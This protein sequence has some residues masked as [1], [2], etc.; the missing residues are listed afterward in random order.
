MTPEV[1]QQFV[2]IGNFTEN[3]RDA[4]FLAAMGLCGEAGEVSELIKKHLLHKKPL[5]RAELRRELGDVMWYLFHAMNSFDFTYQE[6]AEQNVVKLCDRYPKQ[7]GEPRDW[8]EEKETRHSGLGEP[9]KCVDK[10]T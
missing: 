5:D 9:I 8:L 6:V 7:Y 1:F 4:K 3:E 10:P 2:R